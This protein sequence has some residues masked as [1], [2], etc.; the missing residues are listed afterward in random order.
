MPEPPDSNLGTLPS[1]RSGRGWRGWFYFG[2]DAG[3]HAWLIADLTAVVIASFLTILYIW[4]DKP[5][6]GDAGK[7]TLSGL[8]VATFG[9][10]FALGAGMALSTVVSL[11]L[12]A[13][14]IAYGRWASGPRRERRRLRK[15]TRH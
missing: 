9:P 2:P 7:H 15:A 14:L 10:R 3:I 12:L 1:P 5:G 6:P 13:A 8:L 11:L 4:V